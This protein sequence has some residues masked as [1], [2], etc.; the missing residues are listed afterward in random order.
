MHS[1]QN[2]QIR[3]FMNE[4]NMDCFSSFLVL[5]THYK[6]YTLKILGSE[7]TTS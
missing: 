2:D 1:A 6:K 4:L 3:L 7:L 5:S